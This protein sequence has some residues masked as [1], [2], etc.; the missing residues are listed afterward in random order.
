MF[1][2]T[3]GENIAQGKRVG[4]SA[5]DDKRQKIACR[6][7]PL[8]TY[9]GAYVLP[10]NRARFAGSLPRD[11]DT[12][13]PRVRAVRQRRGSGEKH[14]NRVE[15]GFAFV[16]LGVDGIYD[17]AEGKDNAPWITLLI[18]ADSLAL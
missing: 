2:A 14:R 6:L 4:C 9:M 10:A 13:H 15:I 11:S 16:T 7:P 3:V 12:R 18:E 5:Q 17:V 1:R 8:L